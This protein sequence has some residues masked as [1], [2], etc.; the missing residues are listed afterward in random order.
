VHEGVH[1]GVT[2]IPIARRGNSTDM[3][4]IVDPGTRS[5]MMSGIRS[6]NSKAEVGIRS[7]LHSSG[8]RFRLHRRDLPGKPDI[9]LPRHRAVVLVHGCFWHRH[10]CRLS[11]TPTSNPEF[12]RAKFEANVARDLRQ[13]EELRRAGWRV[14]I[15]WECAV[16][17]F[18]PGE[19]GRLLATWIRSEAS[20][21]EIP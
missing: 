12:W 19:I 20:D 9:V 17:Q 3:A 5:R 1:Y 16:R 7:A 8:L 14:A 10:G 21:V 4:D 11:A 15:V 6:K 13:R 2:V 18:G